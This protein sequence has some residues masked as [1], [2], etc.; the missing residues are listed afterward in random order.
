M[1]NSKPLQSKVSLVTGVGRSAGIG[2]A[3][4]REI[5]KNGGDIFFTYW[6]PYDQKNH[7][8][9]NNDIE[10][11]T[12]ELEQFGVKVG[13]KE[14]DLADPQSAMPVMTLKYHLLISRQ[15]Y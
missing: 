9:S 5:A 14:V 2:A 11:I 3:I 13:S 10:V 7:P 4:C 8:E 12:T 15:R 6:H 1:E